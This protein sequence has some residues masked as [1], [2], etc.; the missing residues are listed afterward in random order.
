M[1]I[2]SI[3]SDLLLNNQDFKN[4]VKYNIR[5]FHPNEK[6]LLKGGIYPYFCFLQKGTARVVLSD[7]IEKALHPIVSDI[8]INEMFGG[9]GLFDGLPANADI[10][11]VTETEIAEI[12]RESFLNFIELNPK[13]GNEILIDIVQTLFKK[14][15][16]MNEM[17]LSL[18]KQNISLQKK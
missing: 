2:K 6:I 16:R 9:M 13:L 18:L 15:S 8:H 1:P 12:D 17:V 3:F 14:I 10:I 11:S 7:A 4:H 5:V